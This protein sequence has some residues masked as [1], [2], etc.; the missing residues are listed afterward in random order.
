LFNIAQG[1]GIAGIQHQQ[2]LALGFTLHDNAGLAVLG[3]GIGERKLA[4]G[5]VRMH[6]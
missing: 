3:I 2:G 6:L 1:C 5:S 4:S